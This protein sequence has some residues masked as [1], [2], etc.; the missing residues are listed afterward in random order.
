MIDIEEGDACPLE[1]HPEGL[2]VL[3]EWKTSNENFRLIERE[4]GPLVLQVQ[5]ENSEWKQEKGCYEHAVLTS[6]IAKQ[7]Q[8]VADL[9]EFVIWM[10]GCG[11]DFCQH[12]YFK[13]QRD[14]LLKDPHIPCS[15]S[16]KGHVSHPCEN[17][18]R[19][20][21]PKSL[22]EGDACPLEDCDGT[23]IIPPVEGCTCHICPPCSACVNNPLTCDTCGY[24]E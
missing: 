11:Y 20:W 12:E 17:C 15:P 22:E 16:C 7:T 1:A 23:I 14:K 9:K 19:Q 5:Q 18:G 13:E 2:K 3:T 24:E 10:T 8:L 4:A 21:R 6:H